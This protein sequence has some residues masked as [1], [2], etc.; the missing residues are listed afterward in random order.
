MSTRCKACNAPMMSIRFKKNGE[1]EELC[2]YCKNIVQMSD[3]LQIKEY[4][5]ESITSSLF[6]NQEN[7]E[8]E[9]EE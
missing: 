1:L 5:F 4:Q 9:E 8:G 7:D 3:Y 2:S 6:V